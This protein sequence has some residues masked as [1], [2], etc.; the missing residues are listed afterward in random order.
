MARPGDLVIVD[1]RTRYLWALT[2]PGT[3]AIVLGDRWLPGFT[4]TANEP[5]VAFQSSYS[6]EAGYTP[7][8]WADE[9]EGAERI[10]YVSTPFEIPEEARDDAYAELRRRGWTPTEVRDVAGGRLEVLERA[11]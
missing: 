2:Q 4:V 10:L 7:R 3:P 1:A 9:A 6:M 5:G 11:S 8:R